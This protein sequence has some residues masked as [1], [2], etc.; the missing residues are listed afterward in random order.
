[1]TGF[2]MK[3]VLCSVIQ[4]QDSIRKSR[5]ELAGAGRSQSQAEV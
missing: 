3:S 2:S 4:S 5:I 1:M